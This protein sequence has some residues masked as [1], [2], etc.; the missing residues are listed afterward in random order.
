[1]ATILPS[2]ASIST[3]DPVALAT[4]VPFIEISSPGTDSRQGALYGIFQMR[5]AMHWRWPQE[6]Q[7]K[8]R[9]DLIREPTFS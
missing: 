7:A 8:L 5:D 4:T 3:R 6:I 2:L 9:G 1:M